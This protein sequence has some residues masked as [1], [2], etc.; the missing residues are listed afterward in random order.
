VDAQAF[1]DELQP[2]K[3]DSHNLDSNRLWVLH[4][5]D[6]INKHRRLNVVGQQ[7]REITLGANRPVILS[8][9]FAGTL[10]D[11][12]VLLRYTTDGS[13]DV[14]VQAKFT[15]DVA[16]RETDVLPRHPFVIPILRSLG[17]VAEAVVNDFERKFF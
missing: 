11:N 12:A 13:D 15:F 17:E 6:V 9:I 7:V 16:F 3:K 14:K 4:E 5:L 8:D 10:E 1:I 2:F